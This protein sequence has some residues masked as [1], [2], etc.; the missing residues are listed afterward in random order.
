VL[1][2][3]SNKFEDGTDILIIDNKMTETTKLALEGLQAFVH[4][5]KF[6]DEAKKLPQCKV[7]LFSFNEKS[8]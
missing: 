4:A 3:E 6:T 7:S 5:D 1:V 2:R 8:T